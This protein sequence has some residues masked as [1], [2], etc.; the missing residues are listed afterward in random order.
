MQPG[1]QRGAEK[2]HR[3]KAERG[4]EKTFPIPL[5]SGGASLYTLADPFLSEKSLHM[6]FL[7]CT[8][9]RGGRRVQVEQA[10]FACYAQRFYGV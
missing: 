3:R 5:R 6:F 10:F 1:M 4:D 9:S 8:A 7:H 2:L